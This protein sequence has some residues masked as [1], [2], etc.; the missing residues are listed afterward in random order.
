V[1]DTVEEAVREPAVNTTDRQKVCVAKVN[2]VVDQDQVNAVKVNIALADEADQVNVVK[3]SIA[4]DREVVDEA[5]VGVVQ[6][7]RSREN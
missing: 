4:S 1:N 5:K 6:V 3:V 2:M 7:D